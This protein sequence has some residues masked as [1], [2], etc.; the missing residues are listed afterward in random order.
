[1]VLSAPAENQS[2]SGA[3]QMP[4]TPRT[5]P[6]EFNSCPAD[7]GP[8]GTNASDSEF[9]LQIQAN[10]AEFDDAFEI[11]SVELDQRVPVGQ[12]QQ[13]SDALL[14]IDLQG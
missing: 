4:A 12:V 9:I 10:G 11:S 6:C 14:R 13:T 1:M 3:M 7:S 8:T 2:G 5:E